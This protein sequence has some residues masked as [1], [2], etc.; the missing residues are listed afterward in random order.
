MNTPS[1][2]DRGSRF[3][4]GLRSRRES[5]YWRGSVLGAVALTLVAALAATAWAVG[6]TNAGKSAKKPAL[7]SIKRTSDRRPAAVRHT[8]SNK[9]RKKNKHGYRSVATDT[10]R[11]TTK[12]S[13]G[14]LQETPNAGIES[15][16]Q[17]N[18]LRAVSCASSTACMAAGSFESVKISHEVPLTESWNGTKWVLQE[19]PAPTGAEESLLWGV[20][21]ASSTACV[22]TG[23]FENSSGAWL[24]LAES[25]NGTA[26][27]V[28][29][30]PLP[31][32]AEGGELAGISCTAA[33]ACIAVGT[34]HTSTKAYVPLAETWN[35]AAW[36][37]QEPPVPAGA[38]ESHLNGVSCTTSKAC[39]AV[40]RFN[41]GGEEWVPL[42]E[43]WNGTA[44][45]VQ[46]PSL[47][48]GATD[49]GSLDTASLDGVSC[50]SATACMAVGDF[51]NSSHEE[52]PLAERWNGTTWSVQEPPPT[53]TQGGY[54]HGVSCTSATACI[55]A[56]GFLEPGEFR[57]LAES[58]NGTV[59]SAQELVVAAGA[60]SSYLHGVSCT[61]ANAC[62]VVG[63]YTR[64]GVGTL[65]TLAERDE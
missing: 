42:A 38:K 37:I 58:W 49:K 18:E 39:T 29:E 62:T 40:G 16:E 65:L 46:E 20:S 10:S 64:N 30:P 27:T 13:N 6:V 48:A 41:N 34:V 52:V 4:R 51:H 56:G 11:K 9:A 57:P 59:W 25:W 63:E 28:Q 24:P 3:K 14:T 36:S 47:P 26:W 5:T 45:S 32:G 21:C 19:P 35:G 44:W 22:G 23:Y 55:A 50:G 43:R 54:L 60:K 53:G 7:A 17:S 61:A 8:D 12:G 2:Q 15:N 33:T 1:D 31:A